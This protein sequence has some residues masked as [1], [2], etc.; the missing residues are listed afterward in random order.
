M[1]SSDKVSLFNSSN[2]SSDFIL[3]IICRNR[4]LLAIHRPNSI[5]GV[6]AV[7]VG[8]SCRQAGEIADE[9]ACAAAVGGTHAADGGIGGGAI[10]DATLDDGI[11]AVGGDNAATDGTVG[12]NAGSSSCCYDRQA[13][14]GGDSTLL[15]IDGT[16]GIGGISAY[17]VGGARL[18]ARKGADEGSQAVAI[19]T[20]QVADGRFGRHTP[21]DTSG[22]D[23]KA[24][25]TRNGAATLCCSATRQSNFACCLHRRQAAGV[26]KLCC[27]P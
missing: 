12:S 16:V 27:S 23:R 24:S 9:A 7:V 19:V 21:A 18:Q 15:P 14:G 6:G 11:A 22:G 3:L 1:E 17:I 20:V 5:G 26:V 8:G 2:A 4:P 10:A 13:A 25:V